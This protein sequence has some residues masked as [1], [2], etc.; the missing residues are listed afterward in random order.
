MRLRS[1]EGQVKYQVVPSKLFMAGMTT[2]LPNGAGH[3]DQVA[4]GAN[5]APA[6]PDGEVGV[7]GGVGDVP[8]QGLEIAWSPGAIVQP[9][10]G[11]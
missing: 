3:D 2:G 8:G 4:G 10:K 6:D 11:S 1:L 9:S 5:G 7:P